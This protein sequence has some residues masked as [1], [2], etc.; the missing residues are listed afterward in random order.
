MNKDLHIGDDATIEWADGDITTGGKVSADGF[1]ST[2]QAL[3]SGSQTF[4]LN[5]GYDAIWTHNGDANTLTFSNLVS[6]ASGHVT[7]IQ[8]GSNTYFTVAAGGTTVKIAS[9][10]QNTGDQVNVTNG[11]TNEDLLVYWYDG[12]TLR[13]GMVYDFN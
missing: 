5:N 6:G 2:V 1:A 12:T 9:N 13:I 11:N 10:A 3:G 8:S 4:N 7:V